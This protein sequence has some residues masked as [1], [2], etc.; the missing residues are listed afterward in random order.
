VTRSSYFAHPELILISLLASSD[1]EER[2]FGVRVILDRVRQG[3]GTGSSLPRR[4]DAPPVNYRARNLCELIDW[5][6]VPLTEPLLTGSLSSEQVVGLLDTPLVVP[7][8]WQCHSQS[9]ERAVRKVSEA[10]LMVVGEKKRE[11]WIRCAEASRKILKKP[12][13]K[14]DYMALFDFPLD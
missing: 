7:D 3:S 14:A 12:N 5:E 11:G 1:E 10:S 6:T 9:M 2:R 4:F 13:T 8:T